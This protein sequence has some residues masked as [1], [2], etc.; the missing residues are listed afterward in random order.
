MKIDAMFTGLFAASFVAMMQTAC[1]PSC[2]EAKSAMK[3]KKLISDDSAR[4]DKLVERRKAVIEKAQAGESDAF[5]MERLKFSVTA[6]ELAIEIQLMI[7]KIS[8][9][10]SEPSALYGRNIKEINETRCFLDEL[11]GK[12]LLRM[13]RL[14]VSDPV[15]KEIQERYDRL[16][17]LFQG[18]ADIPKIALK[19]YFEQGMN[20]PDR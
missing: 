7:F 20:N 8:P 6:Y 10:G 4:I 2:P 5:E 9:G 16:Q 1:G 14:Q 15:G 12:N 3:E 11:V 18:E 13:K 17:T 19:K